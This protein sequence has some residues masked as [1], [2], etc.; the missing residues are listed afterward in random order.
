MAFTMTISDLR[1]FRKAYLKAEE[2]FLNDYD[3]VIGVG[4][5]L[6][7]I[8]GHEKRHE[9][10]IILLVRKALTIDK[11]SYNKQVRPAD[12]QGIPVIA[13]EPRNSHADLSMINWVK[14]HRIAETLSSL[15]RPSP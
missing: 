6:R 1:V 14:V 8:D 4:Y 15:G 11:T 2:Q 10:V 7:E 12:F 3:D 5:E 9:L 13:R